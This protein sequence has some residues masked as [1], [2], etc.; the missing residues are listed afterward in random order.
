MQ[1]DIE[2]FVIYL[3]S[4]KGLSKHTLE[5]Y[6]R[7]LEDFIRFLSSFELSHWREVEQQ[8]LIDFLA[9][10]KR[11]HYATASICR[12]LIALK[13]FFRFLKREG[14]LSTNIT[15]HLETPKLW[16]LIPEVLT[17]EEIDLLFKQP[18][19]ATYKGA[20]NKAILELLYASGLRVSELCQLNLYDV[21]DAYVR[22]KGKG[23]KERLVP[24]GK[25]AIMALDHYLAH[26]HDPVQNQDQPLFVARGSKRIDRVTIWGMIKSY[27]K[28]AGIQK[29]IS[30]HTLRHSFATHLLDNGADLRVIQEML[31]HANISSTDRYTHVSR[32]HLHEAFN[33]FHPRR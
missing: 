26:R 22:I 20:R 10:K 17:P 16:Q 12:A 27:A 25:Q 8:H 29:N 28:E 6:H 7:D 33:A 24:V 5:A 23:G 4:E 30:P 14:I 11:S 32:S 9:N 2:D 19:S 3:T 13:V 18:N 21:D 15:I 1:Q 31:G